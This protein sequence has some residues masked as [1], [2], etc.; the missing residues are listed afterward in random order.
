MTLRHSV[1]TCATVWGDR[2][3]DELRRS[4]P[5]FGFDLDIEDSELHKQSNAQESFPFKQAQ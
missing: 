4:V 2:L 1:L 3:G 5:G